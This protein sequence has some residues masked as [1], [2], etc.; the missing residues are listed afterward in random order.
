VSVTISSV[1]PTA[2]H[3]GGKTFVEIDGTGFQVATTPAPLATGRTPRPPQT[4]QVLFGDV[5]ALLV[6]V[7][8]ATQIYAVSPPTAPTKDAQGIGRLPTPVS[9]TVT[10]IDADGNP[11]AGQTATMAAAF[12]YQLPDLT[13]S[14]SDLARIVQTWIQLLKA[15]VT[16]HVSWPTNTDFDQET[17][18]GK[19]NVDLPRLP[20]LVIA[21][22][23]VRENDFYSVREPVEIDNGDGTFTTKAPPDTVDI[24]LTMV[25][26]SNDPVELL[27]LAAAFK[28]F[29]RKNPYVTMP[30]DPADLALGSVQYELNWSEA[31]DLKVT[32]DANANNLSHFAF[33]VAIVG[34]DI[35][36]MPGLPASGPGDTGRQHEA[37]IGV[38]SEAE[39]ITLLATLKKTAPTIPPEE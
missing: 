24:V 3:T 19:A 6:E 13:T 36:D 31:K 20:G 38:S 29:L 4:V 39:T 10:N 18:E 34:F 25:G 35:E 16:P 11:I 8:S 21:D 32:A 7:L 5:P 14:D 28:R 2:G 23:N 30:R 1:S 37:T 26:V 22:L 12:T 17:G 33:D 27:N 9:V 15:Q